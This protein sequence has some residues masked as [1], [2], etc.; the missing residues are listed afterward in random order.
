ML[1]RLPYKSLR[2]EWYPDE[3]TEPLL[4]ANNYIRS[5]PGS[6]GRLCLPSKATKLPSI[7][8][9]RF[10]VLS[11]DDEVTVPTSRSPTTD[12]ASLTSGVLILPRSEGTSGTS[13][14]AV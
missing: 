14:V 2:I 1:S 12:G 4:Q 6:G 11:L 7:P 8:A 10:D 5:D 3:C 13:T 9:N